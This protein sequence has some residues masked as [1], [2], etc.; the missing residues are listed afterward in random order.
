MGIT[1]PIAAVAL[2]AKVIEKHFIMDKS[3]GGA[4]A[5]FSLDEAEFS[6]MVKAVRDAEKLLGMP[7]YHTDEKNIKGRQFSRSLYVSRDIKKGEIFTE[8]N[9]RSIRPGYGLHPRYLD[10]IL[11]KKAERDLEFGDRLRM[12]DVE[13]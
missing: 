6:Q 7:T 10:E 3:I 9:I 11:G 1:A 13:C 8:Q 12:E 4:D 5:S 2:G